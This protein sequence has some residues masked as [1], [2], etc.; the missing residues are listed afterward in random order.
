[1]KS[2]NRFGKLMFSSVILIAFIFAMNLYA[3]D[4]SSKAKMPSSSSSGMS[5]YLVEV[6]HTT[7]S[8]LAALDGTKDLGINKLN[9]YEWGCMVGDHT[10]YVMV[11]AKSVDDVLKDWVPE[12]QRSDAKVIKLNKF[13]AEQIASYHNST[14]Q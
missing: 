9:Q 11:E 1:M 7:E 4:G 8:C 12:S 5:L 2:T 13:T 6:P 14:Q 10:G 3:G